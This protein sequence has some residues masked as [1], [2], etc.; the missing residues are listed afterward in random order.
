[1]FHSYRE[2]AAQR[3]TGRRR[4]RLTWLRKLVLQVEIERPNPL[5]PKA[6]PPPGRPLPDVWERGSYTFW[7]DATVADLLDEDRAA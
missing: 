5:F 7:R 6:P 1:M 3:P 4:H 2:I